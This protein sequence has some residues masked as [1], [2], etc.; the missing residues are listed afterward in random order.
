MLSAATIA[1]ISW[2]FCLVAYLAL[3]G[4]RN[5]RARREPVRTSQRD[6][7]ELF[8]RAIATIGLG[9]LPLAYVLAGFPPFGN[10]HFFSPFAVVGTASFLAGLWAIYRA[11][12]DLDWCF[13]YTLEIRQRH[14]LVTGGIYGYCRHPMYFGFLLWAIAQ[15]MLLP[16]WIIGAAGLVG[17]AALYLVRVP[18]EERMMIDA[19]GEQYRAYAART[20]RLI[21]G[22]V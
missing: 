19:F 8:V 7:N 17:W 3:R 1:K 9:C 16:N 14:Q 18:R 11:H 21:P 20:A 13:S 2:L 4:P 10:Y 12:K 15:A 6:F 5:W 22:L